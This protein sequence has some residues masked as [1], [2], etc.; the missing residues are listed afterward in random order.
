[1]KVAV[2]GANGQLGCDV[3]KG[4]FEAGHEVLQLNHDTLDITDF[5]ASILI[6]EQAK[7]QLVIN[8]AGMLIDA[9]EP[10]PVRAFEVNGIGA[11]NLALLSNK[12]DFVL[13]HVST[14]YVF[15]GVK[16]VPY[17]ETDYPMPLS[18]YGNTKLS[19]ENFVLAIANKSFVIR[20]A[21]LY[22]I[23]PCRSKNGLNFV[24]LMLELAKERAEIRVVDDEVLSPTFTED[25]AS[26]IVALS[27]IDQYGLYHMT[28]QGS[29]SWYAF[30]AKL[31]EFTKTKVKLSIA[32][33]GEFLNKV[34]RPKY[35]VLE[36]NRLKALSLDIMPNWEDGLCNYLRKID[37]LR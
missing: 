19:G 1:M 17:I 34:P 20:V 35:S 36:N 37:A 30:A 16:K 7:V 24:K 12:F 23:N 29:C 10:N 28:A 5:N 6:L 13:V 15:S 2:I 8:T 3:C 32:S 26:Q 21:G 18:V 11:R 25:I 22:G 33:P 4:F 27:K 31:F 14:N 9:C